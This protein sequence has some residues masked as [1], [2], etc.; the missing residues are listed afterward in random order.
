L[1]KQ[2]YSMLEEKDRKKDLDAIPETAFPE[3]GK[4]P[5]IPEV[6]DGVAMDKP[7]EVPKTTPPADA[8]KGAPP[9]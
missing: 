2:G 5:N 4:M 9:K 7:P 3:P 1:E 8:P 6:A